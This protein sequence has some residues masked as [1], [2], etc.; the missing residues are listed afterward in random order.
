MLNYLFCNYLGFKGPPG[1]PGTPGISGIKGQ[2]GL[3]GM[4]GEIAKPGTKNFILFNFLKIIV[5]F[6]HNIISFW[7]QG[8]Y[9]P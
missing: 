1:S 8:V 3:D 5:A 7:K 4:P 9:I 6:L 2:R